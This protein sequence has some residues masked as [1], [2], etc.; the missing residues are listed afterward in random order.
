VAVTPPTGYPA[1]QQR[2]RPAVGC[3]AGAVAAIV[4]EGEP[5]GVVAVV[6]L[7]A[8]V[9]GDRVVEVAGRRVVGGATVVLPAPYMRTVLRWTVPGARR[10]PPTVT[11]WPWSS[12]TRMM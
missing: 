3:G 10:M 6:V 4:L 11:W 1:G 2:E 7:V 9:G 8:V 12:V 5:P